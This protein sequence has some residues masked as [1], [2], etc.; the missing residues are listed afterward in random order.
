MIGESSRNANGS[1]C[2]KFQGYCHVAAQYPSRNLLIKETDDDGIETV[3]HELV[4]SATN[5]NDDIK[6]ANI[7]LGIIRCSHTAVSNKN[8]RRSSMFYTYIT[9]EENYKLMIDRGTCANIIAKT[10]LEQMGLKI[11]PHPHPYN[12]NWADKS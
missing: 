11:E 4:G 10:A 1:Q 9:H 7:Q 12:V 5:S 2:F 8:W 6:V 3:I